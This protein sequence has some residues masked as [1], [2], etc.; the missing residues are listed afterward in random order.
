MWYSNNWWLWLWLQL[1]TYINMCSCSGSCN[2]NSTTIPR[3]PQGIPGTNGTNGTNGISATVTAGIA[4]DLPYGDDPTVTN[5]GTTPNAA[6]FNFGIP[7]GPPGDTGANGLPGYTTLT[8]GFAQPLNDADINIFVQNT[9]WMAPGQIIFIGPGDTSTDPGG[10]YRVNYLIGGSITSLNVTK[11]SWVDPGVIFVPPLGLVDEGARVTSAG[12]IGASANNAYV[13]DA[14]WGTFTGDGNSDDLK[15]SILVPANTLSVD[16]DVLECQTIFKIDSPTATD[17]KSF[18]IKVCPTTSTTGT[19]AMQFEIPLF[20]ISNTQIVHINYKI[21]RVPGQGGIPTK[22]RSKG[23]CFVSDYGVSADLY[24]ETIIGSFMCTATANLTLNSSSN[25]TNNQ[26]ITVIVN[27]EAT[28]VV[29][30]IHHEV[31]VIK[32]Y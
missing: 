2:C 12:V 27:D 32:K 7:A 22:F 17:T 31:K 30:V 19:T 6:V 4:T 3:G 20:N 26:Y 1:K 24:T 18:I 15:T 10:Y 14:K 23:E 5:V 29:S 25:W 21:Q 9:N 16:D 28:P 13:L 8:V 11:L